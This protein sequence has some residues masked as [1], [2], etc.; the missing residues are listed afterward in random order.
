MVDANGERRCLLVYSQAALEEHVEQLQQI[1]APAELVKEVQGGQLLPV[2][3]V[4]SVPLTARHEF[5]TNWRDHY[6]PAQR[7]SARQP[8]H[9]TITDDVMLPAIH[10][11]PIHS[12]RQFLETTTMV[13][14]V[15]H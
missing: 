5:I 14:Q 15:I 7:I 9:A 10:G 12:Y 13:Q 3:D 11:K 2:F 6:Y 4:Q 1:G 8:F